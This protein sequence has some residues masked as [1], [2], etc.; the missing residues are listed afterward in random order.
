[1][2]ERDLIDVIEAAYAT[3]PTERAWL[4]GL[5]EA[6][7]HA[8]GTDEPA[9][10]HLYDVGR[11]TVLES[12]PAHVPADVVPGGV[13]LHRIPVPEAVVTPGGEAWLESMRRLHEVVPESIVDVYRKGFRFASAFENMGGKPLPL[14][15]AI[16]GDAQG[17]YVAVAAVLPSG[18]GVLV[19]APRSN[20]M[21]LSAASRRAW[22]RVAIHIAAGMRLRRALDGPESAVMTPDGRVLHASVEAESAR[23]HEAL[24]HATRQRERARGRTRREDPMAAVELWRGLV[25]GRW[26]L[27]DRFEQDGRRFVV[28]RQNPPGHRDPRALSGR[29]RDVAA[30]VARGLSIQLI[31]YE[32]GL[33]PST[34]SA[35]LSRALRKLG[36]TNRGELAALGHALASMDEAPASSEA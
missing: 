5:A 4:L 36:L 9:F 24:G 14:F 3:E 26:S 31:A 1:M 28:A 34:V 16:A 32:L 25:S 23:V 19:G 10:A 2:A 20:R 27:V 18:E 17:D 22:V 15:R 29:E 35:H 11:A 6:A 12:L 13:R 30:S 21:R 7:Q 33:S 8:F